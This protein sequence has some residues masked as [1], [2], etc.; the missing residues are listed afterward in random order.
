MSN[1]LHP[2]WTFALLPVP[3]AAWWLSLPDAQMFTAIPAVLVYALMQ[4][5][6]PGCRL[7]V[8]VPYSPINMAHFMFLLKL[9]VIPFLVMVLG[10]SL[11]TFPSI[12]PKGDVEQALWIDIVAYVGFCIGLQCVRWHTVPRFGPMLTALADVPTR[13]LVAAYL[14]VG[15]IGFAANFGSVALL[16]EYFTNPGAFQEYDRELNGTVRGLIGIFFRP[17][18]AI[19]MVAWWASTVD[20]PSSSFRRIIVSILAA[21]GVL[22]ANLTFSFN[23]AAFVFPLVG[24][25]A[26]FSMRVKR[27]NPLVMVTSALVAFPVLV[28]L[29]SY[30]TGPDQADE[31]Q[32]GRAFEKAIEGASEQIQVY[33]AAPHFTAF[34]YQRMNWAQPPLGGY[35]LLAS[36]MTPVPV[37]GK[38]F[39]EGNGP[40]L[41]NRAIYGSAGFEDQIIPF[42]SELF[43]NWH[44]PG[45]ALGFMI[46]GLALGNVQR[47]LAVIPGTFGAFALQYLGMWIAMLTAWSLAVFAQILIYFFGPFYLFVAIGLLRNWLRP[48]SL[49]SIEPAWEAAATS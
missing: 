12:A 44:I 4:W 47:W 46:L 3:L 42:P 6:L 21:A 5:L 11:G 28:A 33:G 29:G 15:L 27:L 18:F 32:S 40:A 14:V 37:L 43:V 34:F 22:L 36:A 48:G 2:G 19:G 10:P 35:S 1:R 30:R 16:T 41:Y 17:Y 13:Q 39:R 7:R 25:L 49:P 31:F 9:L 8:D 23:R 24:M 45:V 38:S 26:V 20:Q